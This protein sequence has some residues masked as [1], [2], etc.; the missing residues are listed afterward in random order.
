MIIIIDSKSKE[1]EFIPSE[2]ETMSCD[3]FPGNS[4]RVAE[5]EENRLVDLD[6][7]TEEQ[8]P[9]PQEGHH[10]TEDGLSNSAASCPVT[11]PNSSSHQDQSSEINNPGLQSSTKMGR[12][13]GIKRTYAMEEMEAEGVATKT[14]LPNVRPSLSDSSGDDDDETRII[15]AKKSRV[16]KGIN[17]LYLT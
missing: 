7:D 14:L 12:I 2:E 15:S 4:A 9:T 11:A 17:I 3:N 16:V 8:F 6:I 13:R 5:L 1:T 10:L